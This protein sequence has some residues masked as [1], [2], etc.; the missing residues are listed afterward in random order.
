MIVVSLDDFTFKIRLEG[1][2][3]FQWTKGFEVRIFRQL[4]PSKICLRHVRIPLSAADF[5]LYLIYS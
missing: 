3:C 1:L 5:R 2:A 4:V